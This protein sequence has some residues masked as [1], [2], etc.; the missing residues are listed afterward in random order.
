MAFSQQ[1]KQGRI[2]F[3]KRG[4]M[5]ETFWKSL[6]ILE[7]IIKDNQNPL[8]YEISEG[9]L[10]AKIQTLKPRKASG[11]DGILNEMLQFSSQKIKTA[12]LNLFT[13][14]LNIG[15]F[16][17][18]WNQGLITP[19]FKSG[20]KYDPNNY[21]GIC[22]SGNL[23]KLFCSILNSRLQNFLS[24]HNVLSKSQIGFTPQHRAT[25][26]IYTLH[27]L[28]QKHVH[29]NNIIIFSCFVDFKKAFNSIWHHGL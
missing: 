7:S 22:V 26:H 19:I 3:S 17:D 20:D 21:R 9:E 2:G 10:L 27:T 14:I 12:I 1:I 8:D 16:P 13:L 6:K 29:Q 25:D 4:N 28:I 15:N 23:G 11:P 5:E 24:E 18:T